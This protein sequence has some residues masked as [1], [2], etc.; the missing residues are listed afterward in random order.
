MRFPMPYGPFN[1]TLGEDCHLELISFYILA[2][3]L[4]VTNI[5]SFVL[6]I[7]HPIEK[8]GFLIRPLYFIVH[9]SLLSNSILMMVSMYAPYLARYFWSLSLCCIIFSIGIYFLIIGRGKI[10]RNVD[11]LIILI[12]TQ[13]TCFSITQ[14]IAKCIIC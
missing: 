5:I 11:L 3:I 6:L 7:W 1:E 13:L 2:W 9:V 10:K 14:I 12:L 4:A 8:K